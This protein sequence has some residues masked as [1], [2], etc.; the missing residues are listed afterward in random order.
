MLEAQSPSWNDRNNVLLVDDTRN[1][2]DLRVH[3]SLA[4]FIWADRTYLR[5]NQGCKLR[6]S[7]SWHSMSNDLEFGRW[8]VDRQVQRIDERD[9]TTCSRR[10]LGI[11]R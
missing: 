6:V 7:N 1:V 9:G 2:G 5:V 11:S 8:K 10:L 3:F 4:N